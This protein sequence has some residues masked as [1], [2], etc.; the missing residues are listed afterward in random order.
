ML[1]TAQN[2]SAR[3]LVVMQAPVP[4]LALSVATTPQH[5]LDQVLAVIVHLLANNETATCNA[6]VNGAAPM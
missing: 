5:E 2:T 6:F 3:L 1:S 4:T